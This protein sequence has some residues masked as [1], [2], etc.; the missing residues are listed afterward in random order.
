MINKD[1]VNEI[2]ADMKEAERL[3]QEAIEAEVDKFLENRLEYYVAMVMNGDINNELALIRAIQ[4]DGCKYSFIAVPQISKALEEF[5]W[6]QCLIYSGVLGLDYR[7][8]Y[9][10]ISNAPTD[11]HQSEKVKQ[12]Q[13]ELGF[14]PSPVVE[15][16]EEIKDTIGDMRDNT[17][18]SH[19]RSL[20]EQE[21]KEKFSPIPIIALYLIFIIAVILFFVFK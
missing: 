3:K 18:N 19:N 20:E 1:K 15:T 21:K 4:K 9:M 16:M 2:L 10:H 17:I 11:T 12:R 5:D 13:I 14:L 6:Y 8:Q 7:Y